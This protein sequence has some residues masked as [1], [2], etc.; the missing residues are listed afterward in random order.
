MRLHR[1]VEPLQ[2]PQR[3]RHRLRRNNP[4]REDARPQP[5]HF[6]IL[7][8][9]AQPVLHHPANLQPA[10]VRSDVNGSKSLHDF[11][12]EPGKP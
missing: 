2:R 5:R 1:L 9:D 10:G 4:R 3:R 8:H 7:M 6:A 11:P 12:E